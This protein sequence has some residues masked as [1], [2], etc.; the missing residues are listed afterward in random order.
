M[1]R[2]TVKSMCLRVCQNRIAILFCCLSIEGVGDP[3]LQDARHMDIN[4]V[5]EPLRSRTIA[6]PLQI[7]ESVYLL[8]VIPETRIISH[9]TGQLVKKFRGRTCS[10]AC[11][12]LG[13]PLM[14]GW[15]WS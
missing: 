1:G 7:T 9:Y 14:R 6:T 2:G 10:T 15:S 8:C 13:I 4:P 12:S 3:D 11:V 5:V